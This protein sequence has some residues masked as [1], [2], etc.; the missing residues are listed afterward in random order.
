MFLHSVFKCLYGNESVPP[1]IPITVY[2]RQNLLYTMASTDGFRCNKVGFCKRPLTGKVGRLWRDDQTYWDFS[3]ALLAFCPDPCCGAFKNPLDDPADIENC[4][5]SHVDFPCRDA[6]ET[7]TCELD[8][9]KNSD[10]H[11]LIQNRINI[12]CGCERKSG[13]RWDSFLALCLDIDECVESNPCSKESEVCVN[14]LNG[15]SPLCVCEFGSYRDT[16][17]GQ[18]GPDPS[19]GI[20]QSI[21]QLGNGSKFA[22]E[23]T[24]ILSK[25]SDADALRQ[26]IQS[27]EGVFR[28]QSNGAA[29]SFCRTSN[30]RKLARAVVLFA[31]SIVPPRKVLFLFE[32]GIGV[33]LC[34]GR[35]VSRLAW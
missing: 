9:G 16:S 21:E 2:E 32:L 10:F 12:S 22:G 33:F 27:I 8:A 6:G 34:Y 13:K 11:D 4:Q 26:A 15:K 35:V 28:R 17:T 25:L 24:T 23:G 1:D 19:Y 5:K 30:I 7:D 18:C 20:L 31:G 29:R 14:R 3:C